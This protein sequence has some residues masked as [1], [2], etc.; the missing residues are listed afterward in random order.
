MY[1]SIYILMFLFVYTFLVFLLP[2][3]WTPN[4]Y[5]NV[6]HLGILANVSHSSNVNEVI[7]TILD[8]FI[9]KNSILN[10]PKKLV[11]VRMY[12]STIIGLVGPPYSY[13]SLVAF[14]AFAWLRVCAF[15]AFGASKILS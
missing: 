3:V 6:F 9:Q 12:G 1:L 2:A 4:I 13:C 15:G 5:S 8:F 14:C 7:K 11:F 10:G